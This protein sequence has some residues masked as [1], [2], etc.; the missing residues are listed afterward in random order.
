[1]PFI[2]QELIEENP[3]VVSARLKEPVQ[4]VLARMIEHDFSQIPIIDD[5]R[6]P[7]GMITHESILRAL[8]HFGVGLDKLL[9]E[10]ARV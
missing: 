6:R 10:H 2:V 4:T 5:E 8:N 1:M 3:N 9:V 7:V